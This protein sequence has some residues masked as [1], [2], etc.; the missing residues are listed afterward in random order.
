[1]SFRYRADTLCE[2]S[3]EREKAPDPVITSA[4]VCGCSGRYCLRKGIC[5]NLLPGYLIREKSF[6]C[7]LS[8]VSVYTEAGYL[9]VPG[10]IRI[11]VCRICPVKCALNLASLALFCSSLP[12]GIPV[13]LQKISIEGRVLFFLRTSSYRRGICFLYA[14]ATHLRKLPAPCTC[15]P[16]LNCE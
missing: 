5:F 6:M 1:M 4:Y 10:C 15:L 13:C 9:R 11:Y 7:T 16:S 3:T 12:W 2:D 8:D 14:L